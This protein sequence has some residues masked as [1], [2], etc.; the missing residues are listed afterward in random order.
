[1][2][3]HFSRLRQSKTPAPTED[4]LVTIAVTINHLFKPG[5]YLCKYFDLKWF[6]IGESLSAV[7]NMCC[8]YI[9]NLA[10]WI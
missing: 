2:S 5:S 8:I 4:L 3:R 9:E 7:Q 6:I 10:K 1:M